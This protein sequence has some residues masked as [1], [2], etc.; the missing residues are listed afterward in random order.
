MRFP[1]KPEYLSVLRAAIGVIA[2]DM[3]FNYDEIIQLRVAVSEAFQM[4]IRQVPQEPQ[5]STAVGL[6]VHLTVEPDNIEIVIF[7]LQDYT[8]CSPRLGANQLLPGTEEEIESRALLES[9]MD[10]VEV[11]REAAGEPLIRM[12]KYKAAAKAKQ[13][14]RMLQ[15]HRT[16]AQYGNAVSA[17]AGRCRERVGAHHVNSALKWGASWGNRSKKGNTV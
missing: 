3:S 14:K 15:Y 10:E 2:G 16:S 11:G 9:L 12:V 1:P 7:K 8:S 17:G 6:V 13:K 4:T 5:V